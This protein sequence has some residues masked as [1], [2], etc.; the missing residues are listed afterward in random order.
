MK[1][2][3]KIILQPLLTEKSTALRDEQ[4]KYV[5]LVDINANKVEIREALERLFP[6]VKGKIVKINTV[7][8]KGKRKGHLVRYRYGIGKRPDRKKAI[9]TLEEGTTISLYETTI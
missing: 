9:V 2:P 4:N 1:D 8:V 3:Y 7:R 5:F 6:E